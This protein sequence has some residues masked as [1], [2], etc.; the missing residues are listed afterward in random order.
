MKINAKMLIYILTTSMLI[1]ITS[2]GYITLKSRN[3]AL[4]DAQELANKT[5]REYANIIKSELSADLNITKTLAQSGQAYLSIP[6]DEW[7]KSFLDQQ[8]NILNENQH[9]LA[10]ATSWEINH[11]DPEWNK[12]FGRYLNGWVK[13]QN[14]NVSHLE[15]RLNL[16]GDDV[17]GNYYKMKSSGISMIVDPKLYSPTGK[18]EDQYLNSNIS[19][20]IM[21]GNTFVG[22]AGV[23]VDLQRFQEII[24][25][26]KPF[27][28]SYSFLLSND[29]TIVGHPNIEFMGKLFSEI[30]PEL[31]ETY[32]IDTKVK[33][34]ENFS[35]THIN[36]F[37]QKDFYVF[38]P[39][40]IDEID[41]P[42]SLAIS[43]PNK[44]ITSKAKNILYNAILVAFLGL[45]LITVVI[46][47]IAKNITDPIIKVTNS[48]KNLAEGKID[49]SLKMNVKTKDEVGIMTEAL[50]TS[51]DGLNKKAEFANLIGSGEINSELELLSKNDILGK[52]LLEMR[53]NLQKAKEEEEDR[54]E[55]ERK[56]RWTNE[57]LAK[58]AEILRKNNDDLE[59]LSRNIIKNLV[60][61]IEANQG[62][63]FILNDEE[64]ST[65][66]FDLRAAFA[67]DR[68]K[69]LKKRVELGEG[70]VGTCAREKQTIYLTE[71]PQS[72]VEI[73]SGLGGSNPKSLLIVP[74]KAENQILG[75][76]E[77]ASFKE[78]KD[79]EIEFVEMVAESIA[80]TLSSVQVNI[81]TSELLER[82]QQQS[83]EMAAQEEEM[84][85][86]MEELQ[87]TQ[88]ESDRRSE[89]FKG[90]LEAIDFF[91]LKVEFSLD[92]TVQNANERFL[93]KFDYNINEVIGIEAEEFIAK[94]DLIKFQSIINKVLSGKSHQEITSLKSKSGKEFKL[95]TS[96]NPVFINEQVEKILLLAVDL[97]DFK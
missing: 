8:L 16:E 10:V 17:T 90:T 29:G 43:V 40:K 70:L 72:Y 28:G 12:P 68:E 85:Q 46:W 5:A 25:K 35:F 48:L 20:P 52:S 7:N 63:L 34:G 59:L 26:I 82:S 66:V 94:K 14:G 33:S 69:Y 50:N 96:F 47:I 23:D 30:F 18:V 24:V 2:L 13:D 39:I 19:V 76:V 3:L 38:A 74:L 92:F 67:F 61:Y 54:K 83:E 1:F 75:V 91:L 93:N 79:Y 4:S 57:G 55:E 62:G 88:E 51:I 9:Y 41:T 27:D 86:N 56:R 97:G 22:L 81:K 42:W 15:T 84:R 32:E 60:Y 45:I 37:N 87:A 77:I 65:P 36:E 44:V 89:E 71:I 80:S 78:I 64:S 58:F 73:T 21:L 31:N 6:W 49:D 53:D 11:I 95:I